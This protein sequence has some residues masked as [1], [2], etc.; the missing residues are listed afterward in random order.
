[1]TAPLFD[2]SEFVPESTAAEPTPK[3]EPRLRR[4]VRDQ[5]VMHCEA[6]DDLIP[7][8][9]RARMVWA[10]VESLDLSPLLAEFQAVEGAVGA[11]G[12]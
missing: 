10:Y 1:M 5:V 3:R 4:A 12:D 9:H 6:V 7:E 2:K 11:G 8:D